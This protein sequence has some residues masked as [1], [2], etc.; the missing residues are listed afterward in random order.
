LKKHDAN[1]FYGAQFSIDQPFDL[2]AKSTHL[3]NKPSWSQP[4]NT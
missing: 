4:K 2:C 1:V 3:K